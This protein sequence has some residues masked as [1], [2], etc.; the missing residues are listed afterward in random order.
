M[1]NEWKRILFQWICPLIVLFSV[2]AVLFADFSK[3]VNAGIASNFEQS[4][5]NEVELYTEKL[6]QEF[7][8]IHTVGEMI[9]SIVSS[10]TGQ[11]GEVKEL[12][13]LAVEQ[14]EVYEALVF[15]PDGSAI[16][17][18]GRVLLLNDANY[19]EW[20]SEATQFSYRYVSNDGITGTEAVLMIVP[21][22]GQGQKIVMYYPVQKIRSMINMKDAFGNATFITL[23]DEKGRVIVTT[24]ETSSFFK[25][26]DFWNNA[27]KPYLARATVAGQKA[28]DGQTGCLVF[29]VDGEERTVVYAPVHKWCLAA[30]VHQSYVNYMEQRQAKKLMMKLGWIIITIALGVLLIVIIN[31]MARITAAKSNK[32]LEEK[33]DSDLLTGLGNKL[34]TERRIKEYM[35]DYPDSLAVMFVLDIDNFK[36]INDTMGHAFGD[37]VLRE[38]GRQIGVNFRVTDIIGRTGGDEFTIFLKN[39]KDDSNTIREA[40][41]LEYFFRHF[42][43][44]DY[45]KYSATASIGAAVFPADGSDFE[46]LYKAADAAL[47]KA[48]KRGKNQLAFFDDRDRK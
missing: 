20:V 10:G 36:K 9:C 42:Q 22:E 27:D 47:Y 6:R 18:D 26:R 40:Q 31:F 44:G 24:D 30:G 33:A 19:Y 21:A 45:V 34:A 17:H 7:E 48:K 1:K 11:P 37:E 8:K 43:V 5:Q 14:T 3:T 38:L 35:A 13:N 4:M 16:L 39:L 25:T 46:T 12:L 32:Q 28:G 2:L 15:R 23:L 41:K 29:T